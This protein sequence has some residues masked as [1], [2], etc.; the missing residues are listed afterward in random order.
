MYVLDPEKLAR[1]INLSISQRSAALAC[2][3]RVVRGRYLRLPNSYAGFER[4][5]F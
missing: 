3:A 5:I 4:K 1:Q 2:S